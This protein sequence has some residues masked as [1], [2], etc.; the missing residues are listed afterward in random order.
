VLLNVVVLHVHMPY[1]T[2]PSQNEKLELMQVRPAAAQAAD[3]SVWS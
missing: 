2:P 1:A 3:A